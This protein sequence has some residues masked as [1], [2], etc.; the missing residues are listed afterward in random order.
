MKKRLLLLLVLLLALS[1]STVSGVAETEVKNLKFDLVGGGCTEFPSH[2]QYPATAEFEGLLREKNGDFYISPFI[3][4]FMLN[5][6]EYNFLYTPIKMSDA[7]EHVYT[8]NPPDYWYESYMSVGTISLEGSKSTV[9]GLI[10]YQVYNSGSMY[11]STYLHM[12]TILDGHNY[13]CGV[14]GEFPTIE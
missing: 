13:Y 4:K 10:W 8:S 2:I 1:I 12:D 9:G 11:G 5:G 6:E 14:G 7:L 3:G